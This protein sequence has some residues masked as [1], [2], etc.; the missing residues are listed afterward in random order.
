MA[1]NLRGRAG[2]PRRDARRGGARRGGDGDQV[3]GRR[4]VRELLRAGHRRV[5]RLSLASD[6]EPAAVIDEIV[7]L[8]REAGV[9]VRRVP[10]ARIAEMARTDT[11][12]GVIALADPLPE[13]DFDA[14][15]HDERAFLVALDGVTDP[16]NTGSV[17]RTAEGAGASGIVLPRHRAARIGP[18]VTK[19]AAGAVEHVPIA[20]VS[21]IPSALDR[22]RRAG[23]WTVGLDERGRD[24]LFGLDV[25][26]RP[27][28][29]V[30]GAEGAGL[31]PLAA[32]RCD[33]LARIP[34]HGAIESLNVSVAAALACYEVA[35]A[36]G[37]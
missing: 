31:S 5:R 22:A 19:A 32:R 20:R 25:V 18:T 2:Q 34:M 24:S 11:P 29:L 28:M 33:L 21:G 14:L 17:I 10:S 27:V 9:P 8:A 4:A 35:R 1:S 30:L 26:Q 16:R 7:A 15:L 37:G 3:E 36:R 13:A 12:Q 23:V 6:V